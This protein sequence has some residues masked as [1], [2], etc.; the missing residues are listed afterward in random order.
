MEL[1]RKYQ[2][3]VVSVQNQ[4]SGRVQH[5]RFP[6][7]ASELSAHPLQRLLSGRDAELIGKKSEEDY[8]ETALICNDSQTLGFTS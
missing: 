1:R 5:R 2:S 4:P 6:S 8:G 3:N 7:G